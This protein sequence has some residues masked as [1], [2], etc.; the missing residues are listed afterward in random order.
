MSYIVERRTHEIGVRMAL[1]AQAR[2][3]LK[4]ALWQG[5]KLV[6]IG[7]PVGIGAALGL[8]TLMAGLLY[9]VRPIDPLT[10]T[11]IPLLLALVTLLAC[12]M[13]ARRATK[14][15]PMVA[16]RHE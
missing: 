7:I 1:G 14:V 6:L 11:T 12:W 9:G 3:M 16:L 5:M 15:D 13:P 2:D 4:M 8:A 10:F